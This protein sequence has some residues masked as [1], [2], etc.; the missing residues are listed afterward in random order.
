VEEA[1]SEHHKERREERAVLKF[2]PTNQPTNKIIR[3]WKLIISRK[4]NIEKKRKRL[5]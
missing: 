4:W 1:H 5:F 2:N 3:I